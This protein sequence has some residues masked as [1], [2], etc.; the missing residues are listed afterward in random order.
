M[1]FFFFFLPPPP[2]TVHKPGAAEQHGSEHPERRLHLH[3]PVQQRPRAEQRDGAVALRPA[4]LHLRRPVAV[5]RHPVQHGLRRAAHLRRV[6]P[7]V[8]HSQ[9]SHLDGK[10]S[11][12]TSFLSDWPTSCPSS[13]YLHMLL[14]L[15][16]LRPSCVNLFLVPA[17]RSVLLI[18]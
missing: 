9:V 5:A 12:P 16:S 15:L 18:Y 6:L 7:A 8:Q 1:L 13:I 11:C 17:H 2:V 14:F 3:Q 4:Q 10:T